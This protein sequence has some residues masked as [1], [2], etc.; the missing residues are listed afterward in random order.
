MTTT[1]T[2]PMTDDEAMD[3]GVRVQDDLFRR[4]NGTFLREHVIPADR[5]ESTTNTSLLVLFVFALFFGLELGPNLGWVVFVLGLGSLLAAAVSYLIS[6]QVNAAAETQA[7]QARVLQLQ[8]RRLGEQAEVLRRQ[9]GRLEET[10]VELESSNAALHRTNE[11]LIR[12]SVEAD[13]ARQLAEL[14]AEGTLPGPEELSPESRVEHAGARSGRPVQHQHRLAA[15]RT[16]GGVVQ[17]E[18]RQHLASMEA[19]VSH[20]PRS[21][22]RR[23]VVGGKCGKCKHYEQQQDGSHGNSS[24]SGDHRPR[25]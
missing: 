12:V 15:R 23:R 21:F 20:D 24:L 22:L 16:H 11:D 17:L 10:A 2:I 19:E 9:K 4:F 7:A 6:R 18:L 25:S 13:V 8:N 1:N 3:T 5:V 14:N